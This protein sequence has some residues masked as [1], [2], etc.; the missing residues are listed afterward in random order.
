MAGMKLLV[1]CGLLLADTVR[2]DQRF[3]SKCHSKG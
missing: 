1:K 3:K 2:E